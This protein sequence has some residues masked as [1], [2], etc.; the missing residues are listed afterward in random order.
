MI[1]TMLAVKNHKFTDKY[2]HIHKKCIPTNLIKHQNA[3]NLHRLY[4]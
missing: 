3:Q 4:V 1:W 2:L